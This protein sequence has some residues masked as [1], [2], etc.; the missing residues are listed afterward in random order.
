MMWHA[1]DKVHWTCV[2]RIKIV[3]LDPPYNGKAHVGE[4]GEKFP[5]VTCHEV[6]RF[7]TT[8]K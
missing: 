6:P 3:S 7:L 1:H 2:D 5:C 4:S 8:C